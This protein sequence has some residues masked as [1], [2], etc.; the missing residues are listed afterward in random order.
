MPA[1]RT[2]HL[3]QLTMYS[4]DTM[5]DKKIEK[6]VLFRLL[7]I[8][9]KKKIPSSTGPIMWVR[10]SWLADIINNQ[11]AGATFNQRGL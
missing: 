6:N 9:K 4:V 8:N 11:N 1:M 5:E 7:D 2:M 10:P 3:N